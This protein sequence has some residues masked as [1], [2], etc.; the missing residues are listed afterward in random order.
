MMQVPVID[1]SPA[2]TGSEQDRRHV[3]QQIDDA[4]RE[5][6]FFAITGHSVSEDVVNDLR[7]AAHAFFALPTAQKCAARHPVEGTNR[8]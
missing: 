1:L 6:G 2:R 7:R 8:G 3:A 4:C 5:I